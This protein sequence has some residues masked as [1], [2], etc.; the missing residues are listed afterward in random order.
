[1]D[2]EKEK[3]IK[4]RAVIQKIASGVN[5]INGQTIEENSF[6]HDGRIIRCLFY[7][8]EV[9][10]DV[11]NGKQKGYPAK[12][13]KFTITAEEKSKIEFPP[14]NIGVNEFAKCINNAIDLSR[15]K[16][17]TG[18]ELNKQLKKIG[19][20]DQ[21]VDSAGKNITITNDKSIEYGIESEQKNY[22]GVEYDKVVFN[23]KGKKFLLDNLE[24][25]MEGSLE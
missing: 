6:L 12:L 11:I 8:S 7:I 20:L 3:L 14:N 24:K 22:N 1:M 9:L 13:S 21:K 5:P 15:S 25:I 10:G 4:A 19:L 2:H 18:V 16:K 23:E 17:L